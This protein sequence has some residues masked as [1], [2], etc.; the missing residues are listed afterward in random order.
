MNLNEIISVAIFC[1]S[2]VFVLLGVLYV[3][4][5]AATNAIRMI[6]SNIDK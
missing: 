3:L 2:M 4:V 1:F 5:M 6:E